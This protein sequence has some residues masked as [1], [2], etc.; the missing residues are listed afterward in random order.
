MS[1]RRKILTA[2]PPRDV[3]PVLNIPDK[4]HPLADEGV[5]FRKILF[6]WV[7][8]GP[9]QQASTSSTQSF[10]TLCFDIKQFWEIGDI[11]QQKM[12]TKEEK[13]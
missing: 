7:I 8:S 9:M 11:P 3:P 5:R 13:D 6:G 4:A 1:G 2:W 10:H 12:L